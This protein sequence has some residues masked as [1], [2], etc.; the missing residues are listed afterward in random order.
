[1][2]VQASLC[3][4]V[5][6]RA[7]RSEGRRKTAPYHFNNNN[8]DKVHHVFEFAEVTS[9]GPELLLHQIACPIKRGQ[10]DKNCCNV[11]EMHKERA[12]CEAATV[13]NCTQI[14]NAW[15]VGIG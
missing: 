15:A 14:G 1:M 11:R 10:I 13:R 7:R 5:S 12:Q 9:F 4:G 2:L 6:G 8:R 3:A